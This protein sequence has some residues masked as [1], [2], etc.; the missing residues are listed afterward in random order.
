MKP[1][2]ILLDYDDVMVDFV[3]AMCRH[4]SVAYDSI[5]NWSCAKLCGV[6]QPKWDDWLTTRDANFWK[7]LKIQPWAKDLLTF[8]RSLAPVAIC[9]ARKSSSGAVASVAPSIRKNFGDVEW[10]ITDSKYLLAKPGC[11][12][13]DDSEAKIEA[14]AKAGGQTILF[15]RPWNSNRRH[16]ANAYAYTCRKLA[17]LVNPD[18][19]WNLRVKIPGRTECWTA[20]ASVCDIELQN[21]PIEI[22]D[23]G[24]SWRRFIPGLNSWTATVR[25][26]GSPTRCAC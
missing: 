12:L 13:I 16:T 17:E 20:E 26:Y 11:V 10:V 24:D 9:T 14:F 22:T 3:G 8:A 18:D 4:F 21:D 6:T 19:E 1:I 5:T 25:G 7:G 15:P 23:Y 2:G